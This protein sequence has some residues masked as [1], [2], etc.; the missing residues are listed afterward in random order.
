MAM[1]ALCPN[2]ILPDDLDVVEQQLV[3]QIG[4][5]EE[6]RES[7]GVFAHR[8]CVKRLQDAKQAPGQETLF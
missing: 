6:Y 7:T 2:Q 8:D 3:W 1:C 5:P 4:Q